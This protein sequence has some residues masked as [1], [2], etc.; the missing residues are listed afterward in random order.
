M[1]PFDVATT[2]TPA[3][4]GR[5]TGT[6]ER[7]WWVQRGPNGGIVAALI[8]RAMQ[9][10]IADADRLP[11]SLTIHYI[12]P[13]DEGPCEVA[14]EIVRQGRSL[15]S[16][17]S[18]LTQNGST[19]ALALGAFSK[20]RNGPEFVDLAPPAAPP[21]ASTTVFERPPGTAPNIADNYDT[22]PVIGGPIF[23]GAPEAVTGGWLSFAEP[24]HVDD[25]AVAAFTDGWLPAI[26]VKAT[27]FIGVPTVDLT[28]HFRN[29]PRAGLEH[30]LAVF[31]SR[32]SAGGF[33]EEDGEVWSDDGVLLA[34]SRQLA[35]VLPMS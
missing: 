19:I 7:R 17:S 31:R 28:I 35:V 32:V 18:S 14:T 27:E 25:V 23:S 10:T 1:H 15:T 34:Q 11:R 5:F 13:A 33:V 16:V 12:A 2:V 22:R 26:M 4:P 8:L 20:T 9:E 3:G 24:R 6:F 21:Y 29:P 30:C